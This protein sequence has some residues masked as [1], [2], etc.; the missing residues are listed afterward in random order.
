M[1]AIGLGILTAFLVLSI[2]YSV[3][4]N[5]YSSSE[6]LSLEANALIY[7]S[8]LASTQ[9]LGSS[10]SFTLPAVKLNPDSYFCGKNLF[11]SSGAQSFSEKSKVNITG[12]LPLN[13]GTYT[14]Y[15]IYEEVNG[16]PEINIGL[17]AAVYMVNSSYNLSSSTLYY[18]LKFYKNPNSLTSAVFNLSAFSMS[19]AYLGS[20][21][22]N[23]YG[24]TTGNLT[25]SSPVNEAIVSIY[26]PLYGLIYNNCV[27]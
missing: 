7:N 2:L 21:V 1:L 12:L 16:S 23:S 4:F 9:S 5:G 19:G 20:K 15:A 26:I 25:L 18:K 6:Q 27:S 17:N 14:A 3:S 24:N 22:I 13:P 8:N 11:L 10:L